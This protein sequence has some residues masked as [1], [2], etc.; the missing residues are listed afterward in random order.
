MTDAE[1]DS[2]SHAL[3]TKTA[4]DMDPGPLHMVSVAIALQN[5]GQRLAVV[6]ARL[7]K[8]AGSSG[9]LSNTL[10]EILKVF[11]GG[12]PALALLFLLLF[13]SPLR[14]ALNAVPDKVKRADEIGVLGVSLKSTIRVE[15][16]RLGANTLS[17]TIPNLS[18]PAIEL[19]MRAPRT[20]TPL[21]SYR[22]NDKNEYE[23][24]FFPNSSVIAAL[25]ELQ[26][27]GLIEIENA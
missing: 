1:E 15:A 8:S 5:V 4:K 20:K 16:A 26:S 3:E 23:A 7:E 2:A 27:K 17:E 11:F 9:K 18:P 12:W 10:V 25:S 14:D 6:E 21:I 22:P 24:I 19:L 13:Y